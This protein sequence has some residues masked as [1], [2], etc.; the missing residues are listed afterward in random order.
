MSDMDEVYRR[1]AENE[2]YFLTRRRVVMERNPNTKVRVKQSFKDDTDIN[3]IMRKYSSG[4]LVAHLARSQPR[5]GDFSSGA[6]FM[7]CMMKVKSAE[8][9]FAELP[10]HVR[11][12]VDNDPAKLLDL[13]FDPSRVDEVRKLGLIPPAEESP[14]VVVEESTPTG[15]GA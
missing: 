8:A 2:D 14:A 15:G 10:A 11:S 4:S 1:K 6:D 12:Y 7:D 13:V 3:A 9:M 5:Y